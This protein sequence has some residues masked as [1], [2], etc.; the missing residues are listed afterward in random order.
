MNKKKSLAFSLCLLLYFFALSKIFAQS[1]YPEIKNLSIDDVLFN[2][3]SVSVAHARQALARNDN[4]NDLPLEIYSYKVKPTETI[5]SIAARCCIPYDAIITLNRISSVKQDI[6]NKVLLIPTLPALYIYKEP[7]SSLE[8]L[9]L[10]SF[11]K[12]KN[13][14]NHFELP[15]FADKG[16][17]KKKVICVPGALLSGTTRTFFFMPYYIFPLAD[18]VLTSGFGLRTDPLSGKCSYHKGID[19]AAP[20]GTS[21]FAVAG[22]EVVSTSYNNILGKHI[23][24]KHTDGRS[25]VYGHLS[26][27]LVSLNDKVSAGNV[28]GTVGSTGRAT[29]NHLHF[30]IHEGGVPKDPE[31]FLEKH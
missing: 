17:G 23:I 3:Y 6:E 10:A 8:K 24:I 11:Q 26:N 4:F 28:I 14:T 25:S 22:G 31:A 27:I 18:G 13:E 2:Q 12:T 29:G 9:T 15:L 21:V 20:Y 30:E 19:I 1:L 16:A 5:I 7:N